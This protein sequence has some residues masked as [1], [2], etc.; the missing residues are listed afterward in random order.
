MGRLFQEF[1]QA[2]ASTSS[3]YGG[4]G[5]GLALSRRLCR[6]MGGDITV[7][8][9]P[10]KGSVFTVRL[11]ATVS[12]APAT[13]AAPSPAAAGP[14]A[15][16]RGTVL[17]IDDDATARDLVRRVLDREGFNVL[18]AASG[19]E[20]L[21]LARAERPDV[22]LLDVV[23]PGM[24]GW[25]VLS[26]IK[27]DPGL[28]GIPVVMLSVVENRELG[29][30]LG[31]ADYVVKP[32]D[33]DRLVALASRFRR[34]RPILV[35]DDDPDARQLLRHP[36][37]REGFVV[38][39]A[40]HGRAALAVLDEVTPAAI[41]LDLVMPEM[42]GFELVAELGAHEAW[43]SIPVVVVSAK[44][45]SAEERAQLQGSVSRVLHK[46]AHGLATLLAEIRGL[47]A[48]PAALAGVPPATQGVAG[49]PGEASQT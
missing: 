44:N 23:M 39:E 47:S 18:A 11:P 25:T 48:R 37:E 27:S 45:L 22:I 16:S 1:S 26:A 8:S 29:Y 33:R 4:T 2:E 30:V 3:K 17:L 19:G 12:E 49:A 34:D 41:L 35:V 24:D 31:A 40:E 21:R 15:T 38:R 10:G 13:P 20:G 36:L 14:K 43:R 32:V 7:E 5:L 9:T 28:A 42:D 46:N 6:L